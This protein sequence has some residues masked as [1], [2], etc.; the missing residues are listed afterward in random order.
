ME[1]RDIEHNFLPKTSTHALTAKKL[2]ECCF[3]F[4]TSLSSAA[5]ASEGNGDYNNTVQAYTH[6]HTSLLSGRQK[7]H[8]N[9]TLTA[10]EPVSRHQRRGL[11][12]EI[13]AQVCVRLRSKV[14]TGHS[15]SG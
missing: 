5:L 11:W 8:R 1:H 15:P 14:L 13:A 9:F 7:L 6:T 2:S 4:F 3:F 12:D 10:F